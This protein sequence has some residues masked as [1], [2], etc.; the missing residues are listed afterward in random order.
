[1]PE[2]VKRLAP[3]GDTLRH[4]FLKSGNLCAFPG[5]GHLMMNS[6]GVFIGQVCH[7][8]AA[9]EG[10]ERFNPSMSNEDRRAVSNLML[11][12]YAHHQTTN[13]VTRYTVEKLQQMKKD[14]E[15]RFSR[16]D[17]AIL[18]SLTDWTERDVPTQVSN[19]K[20]LDQVLGWDLEDEQLGDCVKD[21]NDHVAVL[22]TVPLK[23]R[24]Y[25]GAITKRAVK[26]ADSRAVEETCSAVLI[27]ASD[28]GG[29][30]NL[31]DDTIADLTSQLGCYGLADIDSIETEMGDRPAI[32]I[33]HLKSGWPLWPDIV[34][35]CDKANEPLEA[36]TDDLDF[37]R[38]DG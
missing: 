12:C 28:I 9:D 34:A 37:G 15:N 32:R 8:E 18:E 22:R 5:C 6:E 36:F 20:R 19:L 1:M 11:M 24:R 38:L 4:L 29:S 13:D 10:G 3:K 7:I 31:A 33:R 2:K 30:L 16:P 25:L 21:L 17:R 14:H 27:L 35:F 23:L 26:M